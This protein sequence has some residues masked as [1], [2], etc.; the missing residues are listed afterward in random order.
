L[1]GIQRHKID[2][3]IAVT[4]DYNYYLPSEDDCVAAF[5]AAYPHAL[6]LVHQGEGFRI[7]R[8]IPQIPGPQPP[9]AGHVQ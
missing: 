8:I 7:F 1:D 9:I 2:Y 6:E 5:L 4:R 3:A